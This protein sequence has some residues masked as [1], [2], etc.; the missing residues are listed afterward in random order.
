VVAPVATIHLN[1][2]DYHLPAYGD[3]A[4]MFRLKNKLE[5]VRTCQDEDKHGWNFLF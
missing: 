2:I 3:N 5:A 1:G 4:I